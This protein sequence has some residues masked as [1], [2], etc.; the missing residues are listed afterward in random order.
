MCVIAYTEKT[1]LN[2][3]Q[4]EG[5]FNSNNAGAGIAWR[6]RE[7]DGTR[8]V[9]W[10]KGL[11]LKDIQTMVKQC[12]PPYVAHFRIPSCGG[13]SKTLTHPF[14]ISRQT[15]LELSGRTKGHVLFHNG[16]WNR[17]KET[18]LEAALKKGDLPV[19]KWSDS[20]AMAFVASVYGLGVLEL[21]EEKVVAFGAT[22]EEFFGI[23]TPVD[24]IWVTNRFWESSSTRGRII[25]HASGTERSGERRGYHTTPPFSLGGRTVTGS[26]IDADLDDVT[27]E[28][29]QNEAA[30]ALHGPALVNQESTK[31]THSKRGGPTGGAPFNQVKVGTHGEDPWE[32]AVRLR[33][34][35]VLSKGKWKQAKK[36]QQDKNWKALDTLMS[37]YPDKSP[38]LH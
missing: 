28:T 18:L 10:E 25:D 31:S 3:R 20:R 9:R 22:S 29:E 15:T 14:P 16:H 35:H 17:W 12:P 24:D 36:Y 32:K 13:P 34:H 21:I 4:V 11:D 33:G 27:P 8:V 38:T 30:R 6:E 23:W 37:H 19:G 26:A 2:E 1:R 5:M 7:K